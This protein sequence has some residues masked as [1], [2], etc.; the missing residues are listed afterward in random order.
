MVT[1]IDLEEQAVLDTRRH[2]ERYG[3][4][5]DVRCCRLEEL[6]TSSRW[7]IVAANILAPVLIANAETITGFCEA[8]GHLL[9]SGIL[10]DQFEQVK[11]RF[12]E[13]GF[14]LLDERVIGE[15][16]SGLFKAPAS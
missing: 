6:S 13:L 2:L 4:K 15:W 11:T 5:A 7:P 8:G 12:E 3:L 9:L 10:L 16:H 14:T 1:A